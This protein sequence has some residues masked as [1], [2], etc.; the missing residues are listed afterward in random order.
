MPQYLPLP[1]GSYVTIREGESPDS[2]WI[3][4]LQ[5]YPSAFEPPAP[6]KQPGVLESGATGLATGLAGL[7]GGIAHL[8]AKATGA[9]E[10]DQYIQG[11]RAELTDWG[12]KHGSDTL[13]G[14]V[15]STAGAM[16]PFAAAAPFTGGLSLVAEL[17]LNALTMGAPGALDAYEAAKK[18]GAS[19]GEAYAK[20]GLSGAMG[21]IAP[22]IVS[23]GSQ[24]AGA[25]LKIGE[26]V[27][28]QAALAAGEG[29]AFTGAHEVA[30]KA[31]EQAAGRQTDTPWLSPEDIAASALGFG[32]VRGAH[33]LLGPKP[34]AAPQP[35][36]V[37]EAP[38]P[39]TVDTTTPEYKLDVG[40]RYDA[41]AT[42][43]RELQAKR[44]ALKGSTEPVDQELY[45]QAQA[46]V[47]D[48]GSNVLKPL[49]Q[50]YAPIKAEVA[51]L[52]AQQ[53]PAVE[54]VPTA[55]PKP[56]N[57]PAGAQAEMF[58]SGAPGAPQTDLFGTAIERVPDAPVV[59]PPIDY[60]QRARQLQ[61]HVDSL[62]DQVA[63]ATDPLQIVNLAKQH[64]I[65]TTALADA[66]A[67]TVKP[68]KLLDIQLADATKQLSKAQEEGDVT[69]A[70]K[71]AQKVLALKAQGA[72]E[73]VIPMASFKP[74][75]T[76]PEALR[77]LQLQSTPEAQ[78]AA[79]AARARAEL[80]ATEEGEQARVQQAQE[81][82]DA[83]A[84][85]AERAAQEAQAQQ[86]RRL[87]SASQA[88][89]FGT[90]PMPV[91]ENAGALATSGRNADQ[92]RADL[93]AARTQLSMARATG[94]Q[95]AAAAARK[96]AA[97]LVE[98]LRDMYAPTSDAT[99]GTEGA[100]RLQNRLDFATPRAAETGA[101][102]TPDLISLQAQIDRL[103]TNI[104][105]AQQ[106]LVTRVQD[107]LPAIASHPDRMQL[108]SE[109]LYRVAMG[110][111]VHARGTA[112]KEA[113]GYREQDIARML[114]EI[115]PRPVNTS[116]R[117]PGDAV[118][119]RKEAL[120]PAEQRALDAQNAV[121]HN[122]VETQSNAQRQAEQ[123][124]L[125]HKH[126]G[127][128]GRR[129]VVGEQRRAW[130]AALEAKQEEITRYQ[131]MVTQ[132][133]L[134]RDAGIT[135]ASA[136]T[137]RDTAI[138]E[139]AELRS[140]LERS[141]TVE[142]VEARIALLESDAPGG[143]NEPGLAQRTQTSRTKS[144]EKAR[145]A[146]VEAYKTPPKT[147]GHVVTEK[148]PAQEA[149]RV[150][151]AEEAV[152]I[153][154]ALEK[155]E[156]ALDTARHEGNARKE[157]FYKHQIALLEAGTLPPRLEGPLVKPEVHAGNVRTGTEESKAG[158]MRTAPK[159]EATQAGKRR[160]VTTKQA[161]REA[162][163]V[164][165]GDEGLKAELRAEQ[166]AAKLQEDA[167]TLQEERL[168]EEAAKDAAATEEA[169]GKHLT[170]D[171]QKALNDELDA[172]LAKEGRHAASIPDDGRATTD[173]T[174]TGRAAAEDGR[175]IDVLD[176]VAK[177][178]ATPERREQAEMLKR[179]VL[180]TKLEVVDNLMSE[181]KRVAGI[182]DPS[183]NTIRLDREGMSQEDFI[184]EA[185]HAATDRVLLAEPSTLTAT[186]RTAR[187]ELERMYQ[188]LKSN[189]AFEGLHA[190]KSVREFVAEVKT[191]D[192]LRER[193][194]S[195]GKP[196]TL[197]QR[198]K[199][200]MQRLLGIDKSMSPY[201]ADVLIEQILQ[202]SRPIEFKEATPSLFRRKEVP[203]NDLEAFGRDIVDSRSKPE[204]LYEARNSAVLAT[205][206]A[207][208][209]VRAAV[210]ETLDIGDK[211]S[212]MQAKLSL[213]TADARMNNSQAVAEFG[214]AK[215]VK[216]PDGTY[217]WETGHSKSLL[218]TVD[219][220]DRI[221]GKDL[222]AKEAMFQGYVTA[223]RAQSMPNGWER[224]NFADPVGTQK[225]GEAALAAAKADPQLRAALER[226]HATYQDLNRGLVEAA[227]D[228]HAISAEDAKAMLA[229]KNYIPMFRAHGDSVQ[230]LMPDGHPVSIGDIRSQPFLKALIGGEEK[231]LGFTEAALKNISMLTNMAVQN[232]ANR[233][234]AYHLQSLGHASALKD[235]PMQ[236][237]VGNSK[238]ENVVR[239]KQAP[240]PRIPGDT[241]DRF[242]ELDTR[243]TAAEHINNDLLAQ[244]VAG[245]YAT[246]PAFLKMAAPLGD[247]LRSGVTRNPMY[248]VNQLIKDPLNA[249]LM[250]NLKANPLTAVARSIAEFGR[251]MT[252]NSPEAD[253]LRKHGVL[254]SQVYSGTVHDLHKVALQ[255]EGNHKDV[256][257]R[258][259]A[260]LDKMAMSADA[261]TRTQVY[262]EVIASGGSEADAVMA[263]RNLQNFNRHGSAAGVMFLNRTIPFFNASIQGLDTMYRSSRG[264]MST[265]ELFDSKQKFFNRAMGMTAMAMAY[266]A[267]MQD[268][269]DWQKMSLRDKL[270]Y[271]H[272]PKW[273][274]P[275]NEPMRLIAP[276]EVGMLFY[277]LP[278]ALVESMT[279]QFSAKDM[280]V[281][282]DIIANQLP[283]N[284][285]VMPLFAKGYVDISRNYNS[286]TGLPIEPAST[287]KLAK[288]LR[289]GTNTPEAVKRM[290][291]Q[292]ADMGVPLS[293]SQ[294]EYL[295]NTYLGSIPTAIATMTNQLFARDTQQGVVEP[296]RNA[297]E[298]PFIGRF[299]QTQRGMDDVE[300]MY[301][302]ATS[303]TEAKNSFDDLLK[304]GDRQRAQ[305]FYKEHKAEVVS[306]AAAQAFTHAMSNLKADEKLIRARGGM[307][308]DEKRVRLDKLDEARRAIGERFRKAMDNVQQNV[309][310]AAA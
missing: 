23:G 194:N 308:A 110:P 178:G 250:G 291:E 134:A 80:T 50:E 190:T 297:S 218:Q 25:A 66:T 309:G 21:T 288:E 15:A 278:V 177:N 270:A 42:Q 37:E 213:D 197:W 87:L 77:A 128:E 56:D 19:D 229:D 90:L 304:S 192:A 141:A 283:G 107:R 14:K 89:L 126:P 103:P 69:K 115:T 201:K 62:Q 251:I 39:A 237:K 57:V 83:Q 144:L 183:T 243:G 205:R 306:A 17:G 265:S 53:A 175:I 73:N 138:R 244:S 85:L 260:F 296:T 235:K 109:W 104:P 108:V 58:A 36:P 254:H 149:A 20:A 214:A 74:T 187:A 96:N 30:S 293:P 259:A 225:A 295:S 63:Q 209:D 121:A 139:A 301:E 98:Q 81:A 268:D 222:A 94:N 280:K 231:L 223:L 150:A 258:A 32:A 307:T 206:Q 275:T 92:M 29:A 286:G 76:S 82:K 220:I 22:K 162:N 75:V 154:A 196:T 204:K 272:F 219:E 284:G 49:V 276:Y 264:K 13:T 310:R 147:S 256:L 298:L 99:M 26:G 159:M 135:E 145:A 33:R 242:I 86:A 208:A 234:I 43:M 4:A 60:A 299:F 172:E 179:L 91:T 169:R 117:A 133:E 79:E 228:S 188:T 249:A 93:R 186:Q 125:E 302:M 279:T 233:H 184:H 143:V 166:D 61:A 70:G 221:P 48:H 123:A 153:A 41:A 136:I 167:G 210:R 238:G 102:R 142:K 101:V 241:G 31:I 124:A 78:A 132:P 163:R 28:P 38:P 11:K 1:D 54:E 267:T 46:D 285:S 287:S 174:D 130:M 294:I 195:L 47:S 182:Y 24:A 239:F 300:H 8:G 199:N 120:L 122:A 51:Q 27:L 168:R 106:S 303:A 97:D 52:R 269:P 7:V 263:A 2:A 181:G 118:Q 292:L 274:S 262:K 140:K 200:I 207:V 112:M 137:L 40:A 165:V 158:A 95:E 180:R 5:D 230:L 246:I 170:E 59:E 84:T 88:P 152:R 212:G 273:A 198:F 6:P 151:P 16:L 227:R 226:A 100:R 157:A 116:L 119:A 248:T 65:A 155:A 127:F 68:P 189:P 282:G 202:P 245:S 277:S 113:T 173:L 266:A 71:L 305:A 146:L 193:L 131:D 253:I 18:E 281:V 35:P 271:I 72:Q 217:M 247:V 9:D 10:A 236:I 129:T 55:P 176:D 216:K 290:G 114:Q 148:V 171:E 12:R 164:A 64:A 111:Q 255:I 252:G 161:M 232:T 160:S 67:Q 224:L 3:R 191:N 261:A 185:Y 44:D 105:A 45:K 34:P 211:L 240:D 203:A 289:F 215:M 257:H 156:D